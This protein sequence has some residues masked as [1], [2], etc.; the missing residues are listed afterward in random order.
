MIVLKLKE[1]REKLK[2]SQRD[3]AR[4]LDISQQGYWAWENGVS[5]PNGDRILQMCEL[6]KCTPNDLFGIKGSYVVAMDQLED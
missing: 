1:Y 4:L 6:F 5:F 2:L 3:I